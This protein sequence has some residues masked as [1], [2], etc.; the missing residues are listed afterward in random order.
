MEKQNKFETFKNTFNE[1]TD[2]DTINGFN[3]VGLNSKLG[4]CAPT[5]YAARAIEAIFSGDREI[6]TKTSYNSDNGDETL[7]IYVK[8]LD[9]A[10]AINFCIKHVI[11]FPDP[12]QDDPD[13]KHYVRIFVYHTNENGEDVALASDDGQYFIDMLEHYGIEYPWWSTWFETW[14]QLNPTLV[15]TLEAID[16]RP[17]WIEDYQKLYFN[18]LTVAFTGN[19]IISKT[20]VIVDEWFGKT[21]YFVQASKVAKAFYVDNISSPT[22]NDAALP[23][24]LIKY[25]FNLPSYVLVSTLA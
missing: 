17:Y 8:N 24:T 23:E 12:K 25:G 16:A 3:T 9:K 18:L 15:G 4:L 2:L 10:K 14:Q 7:N 5:I 13:Y 22:G 6:W 21:Y 20:Q 1:N 19:K 11:A